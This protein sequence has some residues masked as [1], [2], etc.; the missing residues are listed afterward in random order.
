MIQINSLKLP[1][2]HSKEE[3]EENITQSFKELEDSA[4]VY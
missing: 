3:L 1:C 4:P 2:G